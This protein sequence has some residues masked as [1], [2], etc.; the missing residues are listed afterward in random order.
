MTWTRRVV[1]RVAL[2][3]ALLVVGLAAGAASACDVAK[4]IGPKPVSSVVVSPATTTLPVA[5]TVQLKATP[6]D[7]LGTPLSGRTVTWA[8]SDQTLATVDANGLVTAVALGGATITATS[9]GKSGTATITVSNVPV[10]SVVVSPA[11][12][13]VQQ[14][15]TVQLA[16]TPQDASGAP[17]SGRVVTWATPDVTVATVNA[18]SGLVT[19]VA[20]GTATITATSEGKTGSA[21]IT[22]VNIPVASVVV[23]PATASVSVGG[24]LQLTAT[25]QDATGAPLSG[26]VVT[27]ASGT[28][29][30]ATV[31]AATGR[32]SGVA[33]GSATI[34]ATSEGKSGSATITVTPAPPP[35]TSQFN[36]V[37]IVVEENTNAADVTATSMPY[38][39]G[40]ATQNAIATQYYADT[41]PSIGNYFMLTAGEVFT[42]NDGYSSPPYT[43]DNVIRELLTAGKTWKDYAEDIPS[44]GYTGP[45]IGNY[46]LKHNTIALFSDVVND[47]VQRNNLVPFTQFATDLA[48]NTLP[49]YAMIVPNLCN[50]AHDCSLGTAD[51]WLQTNIDP[52]IKSAQFQKDGVL[53][54]VFDEAGSDN[55]NGGGRVFWTAISSKSKKGYQ[56]T[57]LYQ[58]ASTLRLCL[59][60]LGV[61]VFPNQA[62]TAPDMSEFFTP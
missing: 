28:S 21:T 61:T 45:D 24:T 31:D 1:R 26:R 43:G 19:A 37:F 46:A 32:V 44:V 49:N 41:H 10:A 60:V 54:V 20:V 11:T 2:L 50:D 25:P 12:A 13:T 52:L 33:V 27:W 59:K 48:A 39:F 36:H 38:L 14:G 62:A 34:T 9:E 58:H 22:V 29:A 6:Q 47:P 3:R 35:G 23:S 15:Q 17:L 16:A 4:P 42:N 30:V 51:T 5:S 53:I 55:T 18:A 40:L 7:A 56:S 57:T 8:T